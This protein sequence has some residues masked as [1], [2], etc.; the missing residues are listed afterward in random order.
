MIAV[1]CLPLTGCA[2]ALLLGTLPVAAQE[3]LRDPTVAPTNNGTAPISPA[4]T[5]GMTVL[6][7]EDKPFLMVGSRLYAPGDKVGN[8]LIQRITEKEIWFHDGTTLIKAPRFAGIER[9]VTAAKPP[10]TAPAK[11]P[12]HTVA[13]CEDT[14]P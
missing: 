12:K 10:C 14:Q 6:V 2:L 9:N 5:E 11:R 13:P 3:A 7:R 4:G 1:R 8:L